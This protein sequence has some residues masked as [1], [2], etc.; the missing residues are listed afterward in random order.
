MNAIITSLLVNA[1]DPA[2][3][4]R[5]IGLEP[6]GENA[7]ATAE[8]EQLADYMR[9]W[10]ESTRRLDRCQH[11][12]V[13]DGL[14]KSLCDRYPWI[15]FAH[16]PHQSAEVA[17]LLRFRLWLTYLSAHTELDRVFFTDI[18]D[19]AVYVD[20]FQWQDSV[21]VARELPWLGE[22]WKRFGE[23]PWFTEQYPCYPSPYREVF[24]NDL[25]NALP[26]SCGLWGGMR[27]VVLPI[28]TAMIEHFNSHAATF[29]AHPTVGWDM[30]VFNYL[31][32]S[33]LADKRY[34]AFKMENI[35]PPHFAAGIAIRGG[36]PTPFI[37]DRAKAIRI[38]E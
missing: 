7:L 11:I 2:G 17:W 12:V 35:A 15:T 3:T 14:P 23:N 6:R 24:A 8:V 36:M 5:K 26:V 13:H 37:H 30:I 10:A 1:P 28:L 31:V 34:V 18:N 19:V 38:A 25:S 27:H 21:G 22:E 29:L 4:S 33:E 32:F 9:P 20:P 16:V